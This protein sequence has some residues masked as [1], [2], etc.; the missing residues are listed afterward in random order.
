MTDR[1]PD[2]GGAP[3]VGEAAELAA[4]RVELDHQDG[5]LREIECPR[6]VM[7]V[8]AQRAREELADICWGLSMD[9]ET[10]RAALEVSKSPLQW[11]FSSN[12][13]YCSITRGP[14]SKSGAAYCRVIDCSISVA[15]MY[16][17]QHSST[18]GF[19]GLVDTMVNTCRPANAL[20]NDRDVQVSREQHVHQM[21]AFRHTTGEGLT[22]RP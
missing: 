4:L 1:H 22:V 10:T 12:D 7:Y 17:C 16:A 19:D 14:C 8:V 13:F 20:A 18:L 5:V 11:A 2:T 3:P 6:S 9:A 15:F 21:S